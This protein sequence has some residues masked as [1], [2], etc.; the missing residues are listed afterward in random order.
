MSEDQTN[1]D[2]ATAL[3]AAIAPKIA[4][5]IL[6]QITE[7]VETQITGIKKKN[8]ELL[9]K[10]IKQREDADRQEK[11]DKLSAETKV[12]GESVQADIRAR[13]DGTFNVDQATQP[14]QISK[15]DARDVRK[16]R[17]ARAE[18]EKRGVNVE[19]LRD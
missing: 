3:I 7:S 19:I 14:V 11:L 10:L 1:D 13:L 2:Q 4:E 5:A 12:L 6:P 15:V 18:A 8:D 17:A 9:D 16:Y